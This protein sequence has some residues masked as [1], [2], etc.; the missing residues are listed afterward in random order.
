MLD[1]LQ[2]KMDNPDAVTPATLT[3]DEVAGLRRL[4][5]RF[6][7]PDPPPRLNGVTPFDMRIAATQLEVDDAMAKYAIVHDAHYDALVL[8]RRGKKIDADSLR[9]LVEEK[10]RADLFVRRARSRLHAL[11]D[12][13]QRWRVVR[14]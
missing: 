3:P 6:R 14:W 5:T 10:D 12:A 11:E 9:E 4:L 1:G 7:P 13:R 2:D 8:A